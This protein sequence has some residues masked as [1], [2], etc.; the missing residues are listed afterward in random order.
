MKKFTL[1]VSRFCVCALND[2]ACWLMRQVLDAAAGYEELP[3]RSSIVETRTRSQLPKVTKNT[4]NRTT[5]SEIVSASM[6][7]GSAATA[8]RPDAQS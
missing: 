7:C 4:N 8:L 1:P 3:R 5:L 6:V 2:A